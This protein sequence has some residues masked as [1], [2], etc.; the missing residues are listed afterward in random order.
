LYELTD[1]GKAFEL[2]RTNTV[3]TGFRA[4][5]SIIHD[6][7]S[8][9]LFVDLARLAK[10]RPEAFQAIMDFALN[11]VL[12]TTSD[13][14]FESRWLRVLG[15]NKDELRPFQ[16]EVQRRISKSQL[17]P[18]TSQELREALDDV[19]DGIKQTFAACK[20]GTK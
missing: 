15:G 11:L 10:E 16:D 6:E 19:L 7:K 20:R 4:A 3:V 9:E 12:F 17:Q 1:V 8:A 18:K 14:V 5:G 13:P 2:M